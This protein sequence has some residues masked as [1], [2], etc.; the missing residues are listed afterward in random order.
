[1]NSLLA[2][3]VRSA[4]ETLAMERQVQRTSSPVLRL[5]STLKRRRFCVM[6]GQLG[7]R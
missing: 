1:M 4:F 6:L 5:P 3:N 7:H 2:R